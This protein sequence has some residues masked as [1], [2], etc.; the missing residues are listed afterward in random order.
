MRRA[1]DDRRRRL[2]TNGRTTKVLSTDW[3]P[4]D[5]AMRSELGQQGTWIDNAARTIDETVDAILSVT[6]PAS[7]S[8]AGQPLR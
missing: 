4:L 5:E 1:S 3:S 7:G 6:A 2:L 8:E